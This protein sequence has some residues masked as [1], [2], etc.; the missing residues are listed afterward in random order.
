MILP[1]GH[2]ESSVR[3]LPW[4]SFAVMAL[5]V[6]AFL[7]TKPSSSAMDEGADALWDALD[8]YFEHP[9]LELD[10]TLEEAIGASGP[11][12]DAFFEA[13]RESIPPPSDEAI[14]E[15]EQARLDELTE[16]ALSTLGVDTYT[17]WGLVPAHPSV[18][19]FITHIFM[20]GGWLHLIGNLFLFYLAAPFIE[21]VWGRPGFAGFFLLGGLFA[22]LAHIIRYPD[23]AVPM[24][25]ASG[26]V[27]AVMGAFLVRY[28]QTKIRFFYMFGLIIRG[29]FDAPAWVMLPLWFVQQVFFATLTDSLSSGAG[30]GVA[31]WA[32]VGGFLFGV[33]VA[34]GMKH[35]EVEE[36]FLNA[37]IETKV[38]HTH[39]DNT[40]IDRALEAH[41]RGATD[42]ALGA[43]VAVVQQDPSNE[44]AV[45]A[46]WS[47]CSELG[48]PQEAAPAMVR[49]VE[50]ELRGGRTEIAL[51]HWTE[52]NVRVANPPAGPELLVRL[53]QLLA[54]DGR[55]DEATV[56]L[57]R[58][59]LEAGSGMTGNLAMRIARAARELDPQVAQGAARLM[60]A[61]SELDPSERAY[62]E[63]LL[64]EISGSRAPRTAP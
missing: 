9:Y 54:R 31:Y 32:H 38:S 11:E 4:V 48:R 57:R 10:P 59:M 58:A 47:L 50:S 18:H 35:Y 37:A 16:D 55:R 34:W 30:G 3:R 27:S 20:H 52:L 6:L 22:A 61:R 33:G 7:V 60:L 23:S 51:A 21:D 12:G 41:A 46:Y 36:R 1:I 19:A 13:A 8:Y 25:G 45:L 2:E 28:W 56:A 63:K 39:V 29:T 42:E 62:A 53:S 14:L 24:I 5:C 26:A 44:D 64:K 17:R 40:E 49:L 43:L 15:A